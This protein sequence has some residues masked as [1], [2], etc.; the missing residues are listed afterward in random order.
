[1][2]E[3]Y[4]NFI[5][6]ILTNF[7][8]FQVVLL[9]AIVLAEVEADAFFNLFKSSG[10]GGGRKPAH[11]RPRQ[12][13]RTVKSYGGSSF[14]KS[15]NY[16]SAYSGKKPQFSKKPA[17]PQK[18][19]RPYGQKPRVPS[20]PRTKPA[21]APAPGHKLDYSGWK[22]IG[23]EEKK[24]A[25]SAPAASYTPDVVTVDFA[26][27]NAPKAQSDS[28]HA[29]APVYS[30]PPPEP[31][32]QQSSN[33]AA[34]APAPAPAQYQSLP[35]LSK[36]QAVTSTY[37][38]PVP[39]VPYIP[40]TADLI[41]SR[42]QYKPKKY[43]QSK[44]QYKAPQ[45]QQYASPKPQY[46]APAPAPSYKAPAPAA[47]Y[48]APAPVQNYN[49]PA[50]A[51]AYRAPVL[52]SA[53]SYSAP[54]PT[55]SYSA[56]APAPAYSAPAPAPAYSAPAASPSY[57]APA[58][59]PSYSAPAPA[60]SYSAPATAPKYEAPASSYRITTSAPRKTKISSS[61]NVPR[62]APTKAPVVLPSYTPAPSA[63]DP[64]SF[65][66]EEF[67]IISLI[68]GDSDVPE[69]DQFVAFSF[70]GEY[71]APVKYQ[72]TREASQLA[73]EVSSGSVYVQN[74]AEG[75]SNDELYYIYYQDPELDPSYGSKVE[76]K[77]NI[78]PEARPILSTLDASGVKPIAPANDIPLYDYEDAG[79][80]YVRDS[81]QPEEY[82]SNYKNIGG[83]S[84]VSFST[85]VDGKESG[86]SYHL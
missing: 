37:G 57:S 11:V 12:P 6:L 40:S 8:L 24:P 82:F 32:V 64:N 67:P 83:H 86:F 28:I 44:P 70:G 48:N 56:P 15:N 47:S 1:M 52:A 10:G 29:P 22:P 13:G 20:Y 14:G 7:S 69:E 49:A 50:P 73:E 2:F 5:E 75:V 74:P 85:E 23:F 27:A 17:Y 42:P 81:R 45:K 43:S 78:A 34:P 3:I 46:R 36:P 18:A 84:S 53:P 38:A 19:V 9:A 63:Y 25:P 31:I 58:P 55:P 30:A 61:Y 66:G 60:N 79:L 39:A 72:N 4:Q 16:P 35:A 76:N 41:T 77:R 71:N 51:P 65:G 33:Y 54:A 26:I 80:E 21:R 68:T 59:T 62:P